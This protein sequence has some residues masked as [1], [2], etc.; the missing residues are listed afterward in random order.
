MIFITNNKNTWIKK[1][2]HD[3][4]CVQYFSDTLVNITVQSGDR[5]FTEEMESTMPECS[6][7]EFMKTYNKVQKIVNKKIKQK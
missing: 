5:L 3:L 1:D 7:F 4:I 6:E 2:E